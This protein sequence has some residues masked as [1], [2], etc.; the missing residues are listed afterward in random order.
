MQLTQNSEYLKQDKIVS[1]KISATADSTF[2]SPPTRV[3]LVVDISGSMQSQVVSKSQDGDVETGGFNQLDLVKHASYTILENLRDIDSMAVVAFTTNARTI[4]PMTLT[5]DLAKVQIKSQISVLQP[6]S[7]T[8]L[9]DGLFQGMELLRTNPSVDGLTNDSIFLLTDGMPNV[10]PPRGYMPTLKSYLDEHPLAFT[11]NTFGFGYSLDSSLLNDIAVKCNGH[12]GFI[13]DGNFVG[14]VFVNSMANLLTVSGRNLTLGLTFEGL[15]KPD[16][17]DCAFPVTDTSWG[18]Q[19]HLGSFRFGQDKI[20]TFP[21]ERDTSTEHFLQSNLT[22]QTFDSPDSEESIHFGVMEVE[23]DAEAVAN[24]FRLLLVSLLGRLSPNVV[25]NIQENQL[26]IQRLLQQMTN[27]EH[28]DH[29]FLKGLI[30]DLSGQVTEA[31]SRSDWYSRWGRHYMKSL[32]DAHLHQHCNNFKDVGVANY[33][34]E[35]F[36]VLQKQLEQTFLA[37]PAPEPS[38][39]R[40]A[41][42]GVSFVKSKRM[43]KHYRSSNP[44]WLPNSQ[45][46]TTDN[47]TINIQDLKKGDLVKCMSG[48]YASVVCLIETKVNRNIEF[49]S[50]PNPTGQGDC[51]ITPWHPVRN[52]KTSSWMFPQDLVQPGAGKMFNQHVTSVYNLVLESYH[53]VL[54][55]GWYGIT[56]GHGASGAVLAH[57][58]LGTNAVTRDLANMEGWNKG[59]VVLT[60]QQV[61]RRDDTSMISK[62]TNMF[63]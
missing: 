20:F 30:A 44:C 45:V 2:R 28:K 27:S 3:V 5:T 11:V 62:F 53:N 16:L 48:G 26:G 4:V 60:D 38:S 17:S 42:H 9:W 50:L 18:Y 56:L 39:T 40:S 32:Q 33:G 36:R 51:R 55:D 35:D 41:H 34:G 12:Y 6:E 61:T 24:N 15:N 54:V 52:T 25:A 29:P 14:T 21:L 49:V 13:P 46:S 19:V 31:C 57:S 8:N 37:M 1:L 10:H 47:K 58:Y 63:S 59:H 22:Y 7:S 43:G 23:T